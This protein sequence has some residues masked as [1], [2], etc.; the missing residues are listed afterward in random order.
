MLFWSLGDS[1]GLVGWLVGGA[2]VV[3]I[4]NKSRMATP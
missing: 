1:G 4:G 3:A 2:L